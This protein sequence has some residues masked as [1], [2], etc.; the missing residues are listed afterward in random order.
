MH[1]GCSRGSR[2]S[3]HGAT[4]SASCR[5]SGMS[6]G[7]TRRLVLLALAIALLVT[8]AIFVVVGL[9]ITVLWAPHGWAGGFFCGWVTLPPFP[10]LSTVDVFSSDNTP[11]HDSHF[12]LF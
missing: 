1:A 8:L 7:R 11:I 9:R 6:D 10:A 5:G 2:Q 12:Y 3:D 4:G